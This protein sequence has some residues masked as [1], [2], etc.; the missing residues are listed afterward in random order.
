MNRT[1]LIAG[2][3]MTFAFTSLHAKPF[4]HPF[5]ELREYNDAWLSVCPE[6]Y[7][8]ESTT[9]FFY[10]TH[11]WAVV[12]SAAEKNSVDYPYYSLRIYRDR[13]DGTITIGFTHAPNE[14]ETLDVTRPMVVT[15]DGKKRLEIPF[16]EGW[17]RSEMVLNEY[18]LR[19]SEGQR[20][21]LD[22]LRN[23]AFMAIDIPLIR[24][25]TSLYHMVPYS[26]HGVRA[27]E[28]FMKEYASPR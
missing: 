9:K 3:A 21:F 18:L 17:E 5:G 11:C 10:E 25:E 14:P 15:I 6:K 4:K 27:S 16:G 1:T 7:N 28:K 24:G 2:L 23:G 20:E 12:E 22:E 8:P 13:R 26:L 19:D